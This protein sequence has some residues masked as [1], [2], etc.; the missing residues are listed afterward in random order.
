MPVDKVKEGGAV[1]AGAVVRIA[2]QRKRECPAPTGPQ[3]E[4][5][6]RSNM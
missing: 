1:V 5:E 4:P 2:V 6:Q 3:E